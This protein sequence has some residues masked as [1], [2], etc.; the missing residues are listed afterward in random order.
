[1]ESGLVVGMSQTQVEAARVSGQPCAPRAASPGWAAHWAG[2]RG[3]RRK[4]E[5]GPL[6]GAK[7]ENQGG[8][9]GTSGHLTWEGFSLPPPPTTVT[10]EEDLLF[11]LSMVPRMGSQQTLT[12]VASLSGASFPTPEAQMT[13]Q[14]LTHDR[15][16][17]A[18][19]SWAVRRCRP[20]SPT[21]P[22]PWPHLPFSRR[23][24]RTPD[25]WRGC[26]HGPKAWAGVVQAAGWGGGRRQLPGESQCQRA[27]Q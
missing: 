13:S 1:M 2:R 6:P 20:W 18:Q 15:Y 26:A 21:L 8:T 9:E 12:L 10:F 24:L 5:P 16:L 27:V 23:G 11:L 3:A 4:G 25:L 7:G 17:T 22:T 14:P 19:I